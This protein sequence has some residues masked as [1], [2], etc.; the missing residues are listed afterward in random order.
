[1]KRNLAILL[2]FC[3]SIIFFEACGSRNNRKPV[4]APDSS[5]PQTT[6]VYQEPEVKDTIVNLSFAGFNLASSPKLKKYTIKEESSITKDK[7][8]VKNVRR[9]LVLNGYQVDVDIELWTLND[10]ICK[11]RGIIDKDVFKTLVDTYLAK[12]E[13]PTYGWQQDSYEYDTWV[14]FSWRFSNQ[15]IDITRNARYDW[16]LDARPMRKEYFFE[17]IEIE[18]EDYVLFKRYHLQWI[19]Q[20]N[21]NK[22]MKPILDSIEAE[23]KKAEEDRLREIERQERLKDAYQI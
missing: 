10:T 15:S 1:M 18:Y 21:Y 23:N 17:G 7:L 2:S 12:Y 3:I 5:V 13:E 16:N 14:H 19:E 11:I 9:N 6:A 20:Q 8:S 22:E 4:E